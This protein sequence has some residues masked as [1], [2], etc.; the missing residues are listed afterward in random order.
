MTCFRLIGEPS[1]RNRVTCRIRIMCIRFEYTLRNGIWYRYRYRYTRTM[2]MQSWICQLCTQAVQLSRVLSLRTSAY[3]WVVIE[4][5]LLLIT[6]KYRVVY[7]K[8][9]MAMHLIMGENVYGKIC[10][11]STMPYRNL[12]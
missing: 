11:M 9:V 6:I 2:A 7:G 1:C 12:I 5:I 4:V 10:E 3:I 8:L